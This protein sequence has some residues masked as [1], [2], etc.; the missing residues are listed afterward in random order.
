MMSGSTPDPR[1]NELVA[2]LTLA[3]KVRLL[4]GADFWSLHAEPAVGLRTVVVSDGPSGVRGAVWDERDPSLNLPSATALA[5]TWDPEIAY[6]YGVAAAHEA[7][8]KGV[9]V[10]LGPTINLHRSPLGGRHFEAYSEDP[11]LTAEIAEA[12]VRGLQD[13]GVAA[14]PKHYV[15]NDFET[16]RFTASV[17]VS[18]Q[19]LHELYLAPFERA[20]VDAGAWSVMSAYN[21]VGGTTMT[22]HP[23]LTEP[24]K[25]TWAFDGVVISDWTAVRSLASAAAGQDVVMPGPDGPWGD[26]LVAAVE[27]GEIPVEVVDDKV[28]RI[29]VLAARLGKL[30]GFDPAVPVPAVPVP[31]VL[32]S[33]DGASAGTDPADIA[34]A[35]E[36]ETRAIVLVRNDGVLPLGTPASPAPTTIAVLGQSAL[37]PRTQGGGSATVVPVST[38]S[39]LDGLRAALPD[40]TV[41]YAT[42]A[43]VHDGVLPFALDHV[44]DP[45][46]GA[47]GVRTRFLAADG[48]VVLDEVRH[49][50]DLVW[51]GNAPIAHT[52]EVLT[53]YTAAASGP[54]E[55]GLA[56]I[57]STTLEV[58]GEVVLQAEL[59]VDPEDLGAALMAPPSATVRVD[60]EAGRTY[61]LRWTHPLTG[62]PSMP[63]GAELAAV[64]GFTAGWRPVVDSTDA[65]IAEAVEVARTADVAVV[66]VGTN[67]KVES[68]GFDRTD[69]RLPGRQDD[70]V[71]AVAAVNPRTVVVVNSGSP[72]VM[73][74]RDDVAAVLLTWFGGQE[75]GH[76]IADVLTGAAE[77]GGRL[78]T[79]WPKTEAD[80]P[81]LDVTPHDGV[82]RYDEGI[83]I[84][85][86]AWLRAGI[87]PAYPFGFGLGYTTWSY[88]A[89]RVM[90]A[91]VHSGAVAASGSVRVSVDVT[92][93]GERTGRQVVQV[94]LS[95]ESLSVDRPLRWLAG[96]AVVA[97]DPGQTKTAEV[98][99]RARA[100]QHW[101]S[102]THAWSAEPGRFTLIVARDATDSA[103]DAVVIR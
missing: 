49:A 70:L 31:A 44:R 75:Y 40:A 93:T 101:D 73:P 6:R 90:D 85:Y 18:E 34:L 11:L 33:D 83:H 9:G 76:A 96:S 37:R 23:L 68:E 7:H 71:A 1:I 29:L 66:V 51:L 3:Q 47:P 48:G 43:L 79:T 102:A 5:A 41:T 88:D 59:P 14:C 74:W 80:A 82:V 97:A 2:R 60:V 13:H 84:G 22:E 45:E 19:A 67:E 42:G 86:R 38:V 46:T 103:L 27:A 24:L 62:I 30:D 57:G 15:A 36:A 69:L 21:A 52:L 78:P 16:D 35:R 72:V 81:V 63:D 58:D 26:A 55:L 10:V 53:D 61:R 92:N 32:A 99:V 50:T 25:G 39:P 65:L 95:R 98:L 77:P 87:E 91:G 94:Y 20:V 17:E 100:F 89:V 4:T 8:R 28:H 64:L 56:V 54:I 12:F